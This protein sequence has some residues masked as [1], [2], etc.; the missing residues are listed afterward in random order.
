MKRFFR[1]MAVVGLVSCTASAV[2]AQG[3]TGDVWSGFYAGGAASFG[4]FK[5]ETFD[6]WCKVSCEFANLSEMGGAVGVTL[7]YD[8]QIGSL[9]VGGIADYMIGDFETENVVGSFQSDNPVGPDDRYASFTQSKWDSIATLRARAGVS[10]D[11]SLIFVSGGL[12]SVEVN[13]RQDGNFGP[14]ASPG[15][16]KPYSGR[17]TGFAA[18]VGIEHAFTDQLSFSAEYLYV[19]LPSVNGGQFFE[20]FSDDG[21]SEESSVKFSS[22]AQLIRVGANWRF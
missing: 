18:G 6:H 11:R 3:V 16:Y 8:M 4:M 22:S 20:D 10:V 5:T 9:V 19:G 17:E 12:A 21:P 14:D 15:G 7:G 2:T 13:Y 1:K